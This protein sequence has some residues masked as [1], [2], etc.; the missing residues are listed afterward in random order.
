MECA[1]DRTTQ[2]AN[3]SGDDPD[4]RVSEAEVLRQD[5]D[6]QNTHDHTGHTNKRTNRQVDVA[7]DDDQNHARCHDP[8]GAHLNGQVPQVAWCEEGAKIVKDYAIHVKPDPD[9][10]QSA[11]H[12]EEAGINLGCTQESRDRPSLRRGAGGFVCGVGHGTFQI[13]AWYAGCSAQT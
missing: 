3:D 9:R 13:S 2:D 10:Q 1:D 5:F 12:A 6:L 4:R 11:D 7:R 8:D